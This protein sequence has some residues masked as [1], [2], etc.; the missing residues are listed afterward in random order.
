M[1]VVSV[2]IETDTTATN[3]ELPTRK[4][5]LHESCPMPS[6]S[7]AAS[8]LVRLSR[9]RARLRRLTVLVAFIA[10]AALLVLAWVESYVAL[11]GGVLFLGFGGFR[12]TAQYAEN[13]LNYLFYV[14]VR[15]FVFYP[16]SVSAQRSSAPISRRTFA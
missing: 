12:A 4:H 14:G 5:P 3:R 7:S 11:V 13:H 2:S 9:P 10:V 16:Y 1:A 6:L 8:R 15:L